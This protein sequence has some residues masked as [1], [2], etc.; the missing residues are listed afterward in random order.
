MS[1]IV[2]GP[3]NSVPNQV[4]AKAPM[5]KQN[6][7]GTVFVIGQR[8]PYITAGGY[9]EIHPQSPHNVVIEVLRK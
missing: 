1:I 2:K 7:N 4:Q 3:S 9:P 6:K 5:P 8:R